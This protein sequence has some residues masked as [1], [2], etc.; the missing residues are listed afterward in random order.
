MLHAFVRRIACI[1]NCLRGRIVLGFF[2]IRDVVVALVTV[3]LAA[4]AT[5]DGA[6][7]RA[8]SRVFAVPFI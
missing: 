5:T 8:S 2:E 4:P 3:R 1:L 7:D 6:M